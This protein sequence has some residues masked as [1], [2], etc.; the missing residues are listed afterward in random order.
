MVTAS[1]FAAICN[2]RGP[3]RG[4]FLIQYSRAAYRFGV[5][6]CEASPPDGPPRAAGAAPGEPLGLSRAALPVVPLPIVPVPMD[7]VEPPVADDPVMPGLS[8]LFDCPAG[9]VVC[10]KAEPVIIVAAAAIKIFFMFPPIL[11]VKFNRVASARFQIM[12]HV[13]TH[14]VGPGEPALGAR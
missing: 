9:P 4:P 6:F 2:R 10:A 12:S 3:S 5:S 13:M 8:E 7:P 11:V 1:A 14:D